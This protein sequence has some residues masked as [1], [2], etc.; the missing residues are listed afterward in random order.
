M[1]ELNLKAA[2]GMKYI[3]EDIFPDIS[4]SDER[5]IIEVGE[6]VME[7]SWHMMKIFGKDEAVYNN[8]SQ[9]E[10]KY[11]EMRAQEAVKYGN[12]KLAEYLKDP[13]TL[14]YLSSCRVIA[15]GYA[16][17]KEDALESMIRSV[18]RIVRE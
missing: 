7:A 15:M 17:G 18:R 9:I 10:I 8:R 16:N 12:P 3:I 4:E 1:T 2:E 13:N 14:F 6:Q 11:S 5:A